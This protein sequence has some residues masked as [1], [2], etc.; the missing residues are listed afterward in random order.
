MGGELEQELRDYFGALDRMELEPLLERL[1]DDM[2]GIDE[3][4]QGWTRGKSAFAAKVGVLTEKISDVSTEITD[5]VE[6][7]WGETGVL[8]CWMEQ[9]YTYEGAEQHVSAPTTVVF[10][11]MDR[12]WKMAVFHMIPVSE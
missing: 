11:R 12:A 8:T 6:H 2:Q 5:V 4:S 1:T 10:R 3:I 9:D 7:V